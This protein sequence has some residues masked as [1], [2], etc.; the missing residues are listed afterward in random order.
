AFATGAFFIAGVSAWKMLRKQNVHMFKKSFKISIIVAAVASVFVFIFCHGE[1]Q[2]FLKD[3]PLEFPVAKA[4]WHDNDA[5][6]PLTV[7]A[8]LDTEEKENRLE[9]QIP[10]LLSF[11]SYNKFSGQIDGMLQLQDAYEAKYGPGDY[12]PPVKTVFWSFRVM[13]ISGLAM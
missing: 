10:Y 13:V 8:A 6:A 7:A 5:T 11:L 12:I 4:P 1:L 9:L 3:Q 2:N